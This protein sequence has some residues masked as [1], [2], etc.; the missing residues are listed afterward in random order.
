MNKDQQKEFATEQLVES[1]VLQLL[2]P[3]VPALRLE[4]SANQSIRVGWVV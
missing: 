2:K 3:A 4:Q 1:M